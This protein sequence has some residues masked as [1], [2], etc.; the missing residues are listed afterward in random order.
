[1]RKKTSKRKMCG[2]RGLLDLNPAYLN[3]TSKINFIDPSPILDRSVPFVPP[4]PGPPSPPPPL[5]P[6]SGPAFG[7][8]IGP[9]PLLGGNK[10]KY[11]KSSCGCTRGGKKLKR[12]NK[13][14]T[15]KRNTKHRKKYM[16]G[17]NYP[18]YMYHPTTGEKVTAHTPSDHEKFSKLNY[19]H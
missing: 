11:S 2:G 13:K 18:H 16:R 17:G 14:H 3:Q 15:K 4:N 9:P 6:T 10:K 8:R 5:G 1:M 19:H 7:L 12:K